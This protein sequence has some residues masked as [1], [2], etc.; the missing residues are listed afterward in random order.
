MKMLVAALAAAALL[1]GCQGT[2]TG[3]PTPPGSKNFKY[4]TGDGETM[5]SAVEIRTPSNT[6]G[7]NLMRQWIRANYPGFTISE[8]ELMR[9]AALKKMYNMITIV[10]AN[11]NAKRVYFDVTQFHRRYED[12]LPNE[13]PRTPRPM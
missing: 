4:G 3:S 5:S 2:S 9:D 13:V 6:E 12:E 11:N 8:Q 7:S 10:D 1:A